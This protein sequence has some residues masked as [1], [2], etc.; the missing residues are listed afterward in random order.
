MGMQLGLRILF[1]VVSLATLFFILSRIRK[2]S[3]NIDDAIIWILW[4]LLLLLFSIFPGFVVWAGSLLGFMSTSNFV[5]CIF[6]FFLYLI[7]FLQTI[8]ISSLREKNKE[9]IQKMS[10]LTHQRR[11]DEENRQKKQD[12]K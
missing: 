9:L 6:V 8:K 11:I 1:L 10:L 4:G 5:L 3:L 2:H 12:K 7:L